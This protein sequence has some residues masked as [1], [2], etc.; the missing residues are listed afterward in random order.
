[1]DQLDLLAFHT[2]FPSSIRYERRNLKQIAKAFDLNWHKIDKAK[3]I[4]NDLKSLLNKKGPLF[5]EVITDNQQKI[6][7]GFKNE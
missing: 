5:I 3:N 2:H 4:D 1:M 7:S 6:I